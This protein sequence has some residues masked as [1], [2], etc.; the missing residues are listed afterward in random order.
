MRARPLGPKFS[1]SRRPR[2]HSSHLCIAHF[3]QRAVVD[4]CSSQELNKVQAP[5]K[6]LFLPSLHISPPF[7]TMNN[8]FGF[9]ATL[10]A[11]PGGFS[12]GEQLARSIAK[13]P[14]IDSLLACLSS[15]AQ[16]AIHSTS[17]SRPPLTHAQLRQA[18]ANF[19]LPSS[20]P[21]TRLG[22]NDRVAVVLPTGPEVRRLVHSYA[23]LHC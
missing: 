8:P 12:L 1:S 21:N 11:P 23:Q 19:R 17:L 15:T 22:R 7:P 13:R 6:D 4:F 16:P 18:V 10:P 14:R 9:L 3:C 5:A 20:S 2:L